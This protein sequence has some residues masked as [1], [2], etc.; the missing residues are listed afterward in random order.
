MGIGSDVFGGIGSI[1]GGIESQG[2]RS[3]ALD[4]LNKAGQNFTNLNPTIGAQQATTSFNS[5][6]PQTRAAQMDALSQLRNQVSQ[7]GLD[8]ISRANFAQAQ[9][10]NN[11]FART[12]NAGVMQ[13]AEARGAGNSGNT[14]LAQLT[15][16]QAAANQNANQGLQVAG[17]QQQARQQA[18]GQIGQ[19]ANGI[20]SQDYD[21]A[22]ALDSINRFNAG[23]RQN[24][25]QS[26][27]GNSLARAQ[28]QGAS[29]GAQ[30]GQLNGNAQQTQQMW[31]AGGKAVGGA[32]DAG[33]AAM[34]G[35]ATV[36]G[37]PGDSSFG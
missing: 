4:Y 21:R 33:A 18:V 16:G 23:Q 25:L 19:M 3:K 15:G 31:A 20:R 30:A 7:G 8:S 9:Q 17:Q 27:F 28:G 13:A 10:Q 34:S 35:G 29:L 5:V 11:N 12:Q 22:A 36:A 6:D 1:I 14:L 24:A 2:D 32:V 37:G 26:T